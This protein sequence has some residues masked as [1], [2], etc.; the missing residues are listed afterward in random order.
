[1]ND[2]SSKKNATVSFVEFDLSVTVALDSEGSAAAKAKLEVISLDLGR[3]ELKA[4][5]II[6]ALNASSFKCQSACLLRLDERASVDA[7]T[8]SS[9]GKSKPAQTLAAQNKSS[10][11]YNIDLQG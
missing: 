8:V 3:T 6:R 11:S 10:A 1:L 5:S 7:L 2:Q 9:A 4:A